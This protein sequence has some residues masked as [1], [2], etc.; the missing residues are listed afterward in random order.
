MRGTL[1][2]RRWTPDLTLYAP[3]HYRRECVYE[4]FVPDPISDMDLRID[5]DLAGL[6]SETEAQIAELNRSLCPRSCA[7]RP[8]AAADR[9]H[10][11]LE[12]RGH[13]RTHARIAS[14]AGRPKIDVS[15]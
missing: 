1:V 5:G 11:L 14:V 8:P 4:S 13:G 2:E 9:V 3:A 6:I 15:T 7:P 12:G 10:R